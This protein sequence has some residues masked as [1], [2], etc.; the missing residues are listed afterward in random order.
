MVWG[1]ADTEDTMA[2]LVAYSDGGDFHAAVLARLFARTGDSERSARRMGD[3]RAADHWAAQA[4][5]VREL[6]AVHVAYRDEQLG[7]QPTPPFATD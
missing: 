7:R 1:V 5:V 3:D 6:A 4:G 2:R